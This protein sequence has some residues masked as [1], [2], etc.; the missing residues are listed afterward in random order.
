LGKRTILAARCGVPL[1]CYVRQ[2]WSGIGFRFFQLFAVVMP[3]MF[4]VKHTWSG[5]LILVNGG[6]TE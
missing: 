1:F 3:S 2:M 5:S 4:V 6:C